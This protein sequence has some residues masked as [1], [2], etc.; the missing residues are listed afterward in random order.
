[1]TMNGALMPRCNP[2]VNVKLRRDDYEVEGKKCEL[3]KR[4]DTHRWASVGRGSYNW[5][6]KFLLML[7]DPQGMIP[8]LKVN[9]MDAV[10]GGTDRRLAE[11][12]I[13]LKDFLVRVYKQYNDNQEGR[14]FFQNVREGK[15]SPFEDNFDAFEDSLQDK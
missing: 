2:Y 9:V 4:T 1:M 11:G 15:P 6:I 5:R 14:R 13:N 7:P 3:E 8:T 10:I 12:T